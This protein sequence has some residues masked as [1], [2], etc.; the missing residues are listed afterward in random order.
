MP[1]MFQI[2]RSDG[3]LGCD[4]WS[5]TA[6]FWEKLPFSSFIVSGQIRFSLSAVLPET[7]AGWSKLRTGNGGR[8]IQ[9]VTVCDVIGSSGMLDADAISSAP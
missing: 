7:G 6:Q 5:S 8:L 4:V 2:A 1:E 9:Q 3:I